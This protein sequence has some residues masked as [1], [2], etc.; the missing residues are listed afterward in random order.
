LARLCGKDRRKK[1]TYNTY[2]TFCVAVNIKA[3]PLS[4]SSISLFLVAKCS[5][6]EGYYKTVRNQLCNIYRETVGG[7]KDVAGYGDVENLEQASAGL[8]AFMDE[9]LADSSKPRKTT[10]ES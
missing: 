3:F 9:R 5:H 1:S 10:G 7:W 4:I 6:K 2:N 8:K